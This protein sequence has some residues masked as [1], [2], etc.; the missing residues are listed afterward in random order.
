MGGCGCGGGGRSEVVPQLG[1][2]RCKEGCC[3][4]GRGV[5]IERRAAEVEEG[6]EVAELLDMAGTGW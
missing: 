2:E 5:E 3:F 1:F 4:G 6:G